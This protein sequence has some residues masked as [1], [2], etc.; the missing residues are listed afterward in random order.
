MRLTRLKVLLLQS[1][2][3]QFEIAGRT[4][5]HP[6]RLSEYA[7]NVR[8]MSARDLKR[9]QQFFGVGPEDLIGVIDVEIR[10]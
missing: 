10:R 1:P 5:I 2:L 4:G 6:T 7:N 9:L 3:R 8:P